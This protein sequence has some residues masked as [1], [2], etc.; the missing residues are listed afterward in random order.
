M[1]VYPYS[2]TKCD[3]QNLVTVDMSVTIVTASS[4]CSLMESY[5]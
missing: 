2:K 4:G 5:A 3:F 1:M